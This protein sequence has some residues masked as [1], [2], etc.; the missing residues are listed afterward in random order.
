MLV[1]VVKLFVLTTVL[2]GAGGSNTNTSV[3]FGTL[4]E[5]GFIRIEEEDLL[6]D[7]SLQHNCVL[8]KLTPNHL[9]HPKRK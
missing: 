5:F 1:I 7:V 2:L 8:G 9:I 4:T 6:K 3:Q